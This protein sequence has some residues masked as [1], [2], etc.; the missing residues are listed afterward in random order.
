MVGSSIV[1]AEVAHDQ[2]DVHTVVEEAGCHCNSFFAGNG[3][4]CG[5]VPINR[6]DPG[7]IVC[8]ELTHHEY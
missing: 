6:P 8:G 5:P 1:V 7:E 4:L 2:A 3:L